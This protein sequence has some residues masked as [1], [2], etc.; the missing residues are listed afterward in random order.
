MRTVP[1]IDPEQHW[2]RT[3]SNTMLYTNDAPLLSI[4]TG[5][6]HYART[7]LGVSCKSPGADTVNDVPDTHGAVI[8]A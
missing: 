1:S 7:F 4:S 8:T 6:L 2:L 3:G 5:L